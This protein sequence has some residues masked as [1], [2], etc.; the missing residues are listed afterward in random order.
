MK[1][2]N[3]KQLTREERHTIQTMKQDGS[4]PAQMATALGRHPTTI[5]RE[6]RRNAG[7]G[8]AYDYREAQTRSVRRRRLSRGPHKLTPELLDET[9]KLMELG[10]SPGQI[11][12][13]LGKDALSAR[14]LYTV[15]AWDRRSGGSL[16]RHL[17]RGR[18]P[19]RRACRWRR[20]PIADRRDIADRPAG[21]QSRRTFGHWE[22]DLVEGKHRRSYLLT[23]RE[24]KS[25]FGRIVRVPDKQSETVSAALI[26]ALWPYRKTWQSLTVD[27]GGEFAGHQT[28]AT[29]LGRPGRVFFARPYCAG[30]KGSIEEFNGRIRRDFPKGTDFR[31]VSDAD[32][33]RTELRLNL[34]PLRVTGGKAPASFFDHLC[35]NPTR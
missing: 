2:R 33:A 6:L 23:L 8:G 16:Y 1:K 7:A 29:I 3:Y 25:R 22:A 19:R 24:R 11:E 4:T 32:L 5:G 27:N 31:L 14:H 10:F 20:G 9:I 30:D 17:P 28:V 21:A 12:L 34:P 35:G 15:I 18:R 26:Q 13:Q